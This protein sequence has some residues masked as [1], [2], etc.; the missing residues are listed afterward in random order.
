MHLSC[1]VSQSRPTLD[2]RLQ[3]S[4]SSHQTRASPEA[5]HTTVVCCP[6][7]G[8]APSKP[9]S[10]PRP[11]SRNKDAWLPSLSPPS[12]RAGPQGGRHGRHDP[13]RTA[14]SLRSYSRRCCP[15]PP[16]S[17]E[18]LSRL[19]SRLRGIRMTTSV[20]RPPSDSS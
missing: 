19:V 17:G 3:H 18:A 4:R 1:F 2:P 6:F 14:G 16:F 10:R 15:M 7:L 11:A 20:R 5:H 8:E 13:P 12:F 9:V